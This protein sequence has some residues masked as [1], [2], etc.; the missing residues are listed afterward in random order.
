MYAVEVCNVHY[1]ILIKI[2]LHAVSKA[3]Q[4]NLYRQLFVSY[5]VAG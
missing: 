4:I 5:K 1:Y 2:N 3:V